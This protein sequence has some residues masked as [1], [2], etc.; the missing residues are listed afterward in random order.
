MKSRQVFRFQYLQQSA[1]LM[2]PHNTTVS[3]QVSGKEPSSV[4]F[5]AHFGTSMN[6]TLC[7]LDL[8]EIETY[9]NRSVRMG[10]VICFVPPGWNRPAVH[11]V[12]SV[13]SEGIRTRGDNNNLIDSW[14]IVPEDVIGQ[15]VRAARGRKERPIYG[16]WVGMLWAMGVKIFKVLV[17]F[18]ALFYHLLACSG[19][20]RYLLPL[21]RRMRIITI[22][23]PGGEELQLVLGRWLVGRC[24]PGMEHW[25]IRRPFR[26][27]MDEDSLPR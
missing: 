1:G 26:L 20:L 12:V 16:G 11:R 5:C 25:W 24:K 27:F 9:G 17:R 15:V 19:V 14:V 13:T 4:Y 22:N 21:H 10:D 23:Q 8:L 6:P 2:L 3:S 18:P 7:E